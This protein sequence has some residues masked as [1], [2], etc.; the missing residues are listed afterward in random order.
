MFKALSAEYFYDYFK[1]RVAKGISVRLI[2]PDT[3]ESRRVVANDKAEMRATYLVPKDKFYFSVETNIY[4]NKIM[5][6]SWREKFGIIIE[7]EEIA[8]AQ[9][10]IFE[11][12]W[13]GA[14]HL[15][16]WNS[17]DPTISSP[18]PPGLRL[19]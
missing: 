4:D 17:L 3:L 1:R 10:K 16:V 14:K 9:K 6:A 5:V 8:T 12:A 19:T 15:Q 18:L 2:A 11:L 7:S 13:E